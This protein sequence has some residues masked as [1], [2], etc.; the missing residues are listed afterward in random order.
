MGGTKRRLRVEPRLI[1]KA[2]KPKGGKRWL[3]NRVS[4]TG[5]W[6]RTLSDRSPS[7]NLH[8]DYALRTWHAPC[9]GRYILTKR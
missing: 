3:T 8:F 9:I 7:R 1:H 4:E 2:P 5:A 6:R